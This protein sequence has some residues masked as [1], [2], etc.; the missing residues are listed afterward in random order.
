M[1]IF[2]ND[3]KTGELKHKGVLRPLVGINIVTDKGKIEV[4]GV[5]HNRIDVERDGRILTII[6]GWIE[7]K[8]AIFFL[9][10][11]P[12]INIERNFTSQDERIDY[13]EY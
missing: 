8:I 5:Y 6:L 10:F 2:V 4:D 9:P 12:F 13:G 3:F 11:W 7:P 1:K